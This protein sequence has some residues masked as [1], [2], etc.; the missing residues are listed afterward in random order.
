MTPACRR[1]LEVMAATHPR[2]ARYSNATEPPVPGQRAGA[3]VSSST[4]DWLVEHGL[5]EIAGEPWLRRLT[6]AGLTA[7]A[8]NG[9]EVRS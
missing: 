8:D 4:A 6:A 5:A 9:I 1:A 2:P 7:C 3:L